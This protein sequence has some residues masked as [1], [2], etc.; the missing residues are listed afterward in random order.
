MSRIIAL[1]SV[2]LVLPACGEEVRPVTNATAQ[3]TAQTTAQTTW[4]LDPVLTL[5]SWD[6]DITFGSITGIAVRPSGEILVLDRLESVVFVFDESGNKLDEIG[7]RGAGPGELSNLVVGVFLTESGVLVIPDLG[8]SRVSFFNADNSYSHSFPIDRMFPLPTMMWAAQGDDRILKQV[9]PLPSIPGLPTN[10]PSEPG[11]MAVGH[12]GTEHGMVTTFEMQSAI[13]IGA[14]GKMSTRVFFDFPVWTTTSEGHLV[15]GMSGTYHLEVRDSEGTLI[16][17]ITRQMGRK[18]VTRRIRDSFTDR[19]ME[20][21]E[22]LPPGAADLI[23]EPIFADSLPLLG[24]VMRGPNGTIMVARGPG[25]VDDYAPNGGDPLDED[26]AAAYDVL[27]LSG[28]FL[29]VMQFPPR[30]RLM[31]ALGN[32]VYGVA[33][34]EFDVETVVVYAVTPPSSDPR[35]D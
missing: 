17:E 32:H 15:V 25:L 29:G 35:E 4:T 6:G 21:F 27:Q 8:N 30:F 23:G 24:G 11:I 34:D 28:D 31:A 3:A 12:D 5:G 2:L 13:E 9:Q 14:D 20:Q 1:C 19:L 7:R 16:G 18:P 26:P 10:G 33:R 22:G